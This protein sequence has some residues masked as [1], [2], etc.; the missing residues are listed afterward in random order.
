MTSFSSELLCL[1]QGVGYQLPTGTYFF[2]ICRSLVPKRRKFSYGLIVVEIQPIKAETHFTRLT[3]G[4]NLVYYPGDVSTPIAD[5]ITLK[6]FLSN[7]IS[8]LGSL[9][10]TSNI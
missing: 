10:M 9:S 2:P 5:V 1:A 3:V 4:V 6:V 7:K 8:T